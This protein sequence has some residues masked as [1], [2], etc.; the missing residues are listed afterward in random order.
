VS[1]HGLKGFSDDRIESHEHR[2][3]L[4]FVVDA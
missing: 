1:T 2:V 3:P 4:R